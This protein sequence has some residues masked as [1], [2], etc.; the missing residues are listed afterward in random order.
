MYKGLHVKYRLFLSD[1]NETGIFSAHFRYLLIYQ[2]S[3]KSVKWESSSMGT[4]GQRDMTI[5][6]VTYRCFENATK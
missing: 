4:D 3:K 6:I 5:V 1:C 2:I